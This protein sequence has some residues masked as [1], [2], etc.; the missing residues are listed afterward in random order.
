MNVSTSN[1]TVS[2]EEVKQRAIA[3]TTMLHRYGS[4]PRHSCA[5]SNE[6]VR[7]GVEFHHDLARCYQHSQSDD[8][9]EYE[10]LEAGATYHFFVCMEAPN[11]ERRVGPRLSFSVPISPSL[12]FV[13]SPRLIG[14]FSINGG[15]VEFQTTGAGIAHAV[16]MSAGSVPFD[17]DEVKYPDLTSSAM[18]CN[19]S[20]TIH[21]TSMT[22]ISLSDCNGLG[23]GNTY[24]VF[25]YIE[26]RHYGSLSGAIPVTVGWFVE[27]PHVVGVVTPFG[28]SVSLTTYQNGRVFGMLERAGTINSTHTNGS[29]TCDEIKRRAIAETTIMHRFTTSPRYSCAF[30]NVSVLVVL[31]LDMILLVVLRI[32]RVT[33]HDYHKCS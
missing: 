29:S 14:T 31:S 3:E 7:A 18:H 25:I 1:M 30:N 15:V 8:T 33:M 32:H 20:V 11:R 19:A 26:S 4:S 28:F 22:N 2:C 21:D 9:P 6:S 27:T 24:S 13:S 5:F 23:Y 16:L 12:M 17:A 10:M